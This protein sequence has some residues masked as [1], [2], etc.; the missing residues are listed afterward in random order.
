[1][2][3]AYVCTSCS[4]TP[5]FPFLGIVLEKFKHI[6]SVSFIRAHVFSLCSVCVLDLLVCVLLSV[7]V[8]VP[9]YIYYHDCGRVIFALDPI[10]SKGTMACAVR[11]CLS[12]IEVIDCGLR[13]TLESAERALHWQMP[14]H[15]LLCTYD[16]YSGWANTHTHSNTGAHKFCF[17]LLCCLL[18]K[19]NES[20]KCK[21]LLNWFPQNLM[22]ACC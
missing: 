20:R 3:F 1:M 22:L 21:S 19:L 4:S 11:I 16:C 15:T 12:V 18:A 10:A 5:G 2:L 14:F 13:C 9:R 8:S 7:F 17:G 6:L